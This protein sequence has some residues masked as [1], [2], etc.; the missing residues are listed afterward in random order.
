[1]PD[2]AEKDCYLCRVQGTRAAQRIAGHAGGSPF[3]EGS[4]DITE[5]PY[6]PLTS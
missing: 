3:W 4:I 6:S 5:E 1:V 2:T